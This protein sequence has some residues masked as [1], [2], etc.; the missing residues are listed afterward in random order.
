MTSLHG[1]STSAWSASRRSRAAHRF[2]HHV[3]GA[4]RPEA[5]T[6]RY[7]AGLVGINA[8][9]PGA[10]R[11]GTASRRGQRRLVRWPAAPGQP[12]TSVGGTLMLRSAWVGPQ[13]AAVARGRDT[14]RRSLRHRPGWFTYAGL[15]ADRILDRVR[16]SSDAPPSAPQRDCADRVSPRLRASRTGGSIHRWLLAAEH[17]PLV[18]SSNRQPSYGSVTCSLRMQ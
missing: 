16:I 10:C 1:A 7:P 13:L 3:V 2:V 8:T 5:R 11:W 14:E 15:S 12:R 9:G 17:D 6:A 18:Q 4:D